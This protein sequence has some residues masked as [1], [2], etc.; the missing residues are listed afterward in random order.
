MH[1]R[2]RWC[3]MGTLPTLRHTRLSGRPIRYTSHHCTRSRPVPTVPALRCIRTSTR[4]TMVGAP[5]RVRFSGKVRIALK[6]D[7]SETPHTDLLYFIWGSLDDKSIQLCNSGLEPGISHIVPP[8]ESRTNHS[9][10]STQHAVCA[11]ADISTVVALS[12][13]ARRRKAATRARGAANG[14][15]LLISINAKCR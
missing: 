13:V 15:V 8:A 11:C 7:K 5:F 12:L 3:P 2:I 1:L 9:L 10:V 14:L 6:I 4:L